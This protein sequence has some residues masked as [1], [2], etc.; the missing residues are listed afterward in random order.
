MFFLIVLGARDGEKNR[1]GFGAVL[2]EFSRGGWRWGG[3]GGSADQRARCDR[4]CRACD[5]GGCA[6]WLT[7]RAAVARLARVSAVFARALT[8]EMHSVSTGR[9][10]RDIHIRAGPPRRA[11]I[12]THRS[13]AQRFDRV[14]SSARGGA[15]RSN[16]QGLE[17]P[18]EA[19]IHIA[20]ARFEWMRPMLTVRIHRHSSRLTR[21]MSTSRLRREAIAKRARDGLV[22]AAAGLAAVFCR[23]RRRHSPL[24]CTVRRVVWSAGYPH[25]SFRRE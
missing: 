20:I 18:V 3:N 10:G 22:R 4:R 14:F 23:D 17:S 9:G 25:R 8:V 1:E 21:R 7:S 24:K 12:R 6:G 15:H 13:V 5:A 2:R 11:G 19:Y 16:A